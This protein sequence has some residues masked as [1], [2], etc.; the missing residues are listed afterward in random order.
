MIKTET[1]RKKTLQKLRLN[2]P[3]TFFTEWSAPLDASALFL[4]NPSNFQ[5]IFFS[6]YL[7]INWHIYFAII[8]I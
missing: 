1:D 6:I 8:T 7:F 2:I 3:F 4:S 5:F